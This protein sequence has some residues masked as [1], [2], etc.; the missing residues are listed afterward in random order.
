LEV[1]LTDAVALLADDRDGYVPPPAL[2]L[3]APA[4]GALFTKSTVDAYVAAVLELWRVQVAHGNGNVENP[5]G[6]AVRGFLEQRGRQR[7]KLD[8]EAYKDRGGDGIQ[9]GYSL[10]EWLRIQ[11]ILLN[12]AAYT[13]QSLRTRADLLLGHYYLLRGEN[14]RKMELADLSLL[15][16]PATEGPTTCGCL[17]SLLQD[18][19]MNK[20]ARKEFMGALRHKDPLLCTQG[21]LAQL[22]FWRWHVTGEAPPTFRCRSD[23]YRIKVL[24]GQDREQELS[25]PTQLQ[26]TWRVFGAAGIISATKTHLPRAQGAKEAEI[27]G[28][29]LGQISQAGRWNQSILCQAYLTHLPRQFM[30]VV[31]GFSPSAG[32]YFLA[33]AAHEPPY[34]L[35]K[36]LWPW[37]EEWEARFEARACRQ[38]W[39]QG[40]LDEDDLAADGFLKLMR[41]LRLV[42]LQDLAVLQPRYPAL[43]F[44]AYAPFCGPEWDGFAV[45]V[46]ADA[47]AGAE[48]QSL[49]LQRALPELSS[50]LESSREA[51]LRS[52]QRL[53]NQQ[54]AALQ[55]QAATLQALQAQLERV[56]HTPITFTL[57]G[58][59]VAALPVPAASLAVMPLPAVPLGPAVVGGPVAA[60]A[61]TATAATDAAGLPTLTALARV[62]TV[63][64]AWREWQEGLAGRPALRELEERWGSRWRPGNAIRIAFSRRKVIWDEILA[65]TARGKSVDEVIA[66]LELL[67]AGRSL[68]SLVEE[69]KRRRE[70][71]TPTPARGPGPGAVRGQLRRGRYGRWGRRGGPLPRQVIRASKGP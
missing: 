48:P 60:A 28:T 15:D 69:L 3:A 51:V 13:P 59:P 61:A 21:A 7:G 71:V 52:V 66:E 70:Y 22:F 40:G 10:D 47:I 62:F 67:R 11:D 33:R 37:I 30:R 24:V 18:G 20:T 27:R 54:A 19:K 29:S 34:G 43:P 14:R 65:R 38:T 41:R 32:D 5:R 26:E 46:Q 45:A 4:E 35:Q 12:G 50:V 39:A 25:Y 2:E 6:I 49:L 55:A 57:G 58:G 42:L 9:A 8:R 64:D 17:V 23:W 1:P 16:Y 63:K 31:A 53:A 68:S 44:F 36:Q 56:L